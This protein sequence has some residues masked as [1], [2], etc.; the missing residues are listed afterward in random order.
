MVV[1]SAFVMFGLVISVAIH[2]HYKYRKPEPIEPERPSP[3]KGAI[4]ATFLFCMFGLVLLLGV[5]IGKIDWQWLA[6]RWWWLAAFYILLLFFCIKVV[7]YGYQGKSP[8]EL[9]RIFQNTI[10]AEEFGNKQAKDRGVP[11]R[12]LKLYGERKIGRVSTACVIGEIDYKKYLGILSKMT[13]D[14]IFFSPEPKL[15]EKIEISLTNTIIEGEP[16][17]EE[18]WIAQKG[19]QPVAQPQPTEGG[20]MP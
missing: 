6:D 9:I 17:A 12:F 5:V 10:A 19:R 15:I 3:I 4:L 1:A 13:G 2:A 20:G 8:E 16:A 7:M 14:V 11:G 18:E